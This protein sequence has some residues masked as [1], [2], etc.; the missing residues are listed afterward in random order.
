M[1][2][3]LRHIGLFGCFI[4]TAY[5]KPAAQNARIASSGSAV[6][7]RE[8]DGSDELVKCRLTKRSARNPRVKLVGQETDLIRA[9]LHQIILPQRGV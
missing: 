5:Q 9:N 8:L 2:A 7:S 4:I 6:K 3:G 1:S